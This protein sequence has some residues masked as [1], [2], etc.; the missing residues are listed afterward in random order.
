MTDDHPERIRNVRLAVN[1]LMEQRDGLLTTVHA[2]HEA[3]LSRM[4]GFDN[5]VDEQYRQL[6]DVDL[7][8]MCASA[9]AEFERLEAE[10]RDTQ[11]V[12]ADDIFKW[13]FRSRGR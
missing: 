6:S 12:E 11:P 9:M 8:N 13:M 5:L 2:M 3:M 4:G 1:K 7:M 10:E